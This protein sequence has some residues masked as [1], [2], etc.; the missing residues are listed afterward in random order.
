M[1]EEESRFNPMQTVKR[2]LFAMRNGV[3]A[4]TL[5]RAG[6]PFSIIFGVN[7]P[8]LVEIANET[9]K[10]EELAEKLWANSTTRESM[11]IAPMLMPYETFT[12]DDARRWIESVPAYEVADLLCHRLLRHEPYALDLALGLIAETDDMR[13]YTGLRLMCNIAHLYPVQARE[14]GI[15]EFAAANRSTRQMADILASY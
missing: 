3:I 15:R 1:N 6:S 13:H 4:D 11:L 14:I 2:R 8:Q 7:L 9:G 5:R 10:N 12:I